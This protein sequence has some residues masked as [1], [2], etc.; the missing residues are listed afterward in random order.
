MIVIHY[1]QSF[2]AFRDA[3]HIFRDALDISKDAWH[4]LRDIYHIY[5][6]AREMFIV[7]QHISG[8]KDAHDISRGPQ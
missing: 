1:I 7:A 8:N 5:R 2:S 3:R 4:L 6:D